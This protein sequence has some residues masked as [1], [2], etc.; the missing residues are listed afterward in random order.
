MNDYPFLTQNANLCN[1]KFNIDI[2]FA[3]NFVNN[4][5]L[6]SLNNFAELSNSFLSNINNIIFN[7][8]HIGSFK[9]IVLMVE[10]RETMKHLGLEMFI[11]NLEGRSE[12]K[13]ETSL[14]DVKL[15]YPEP[16]VA[17]PSFNHEEI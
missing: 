10:R 8:K 13:W 14:P 1:F 12:P 11:D 16:F 4:F 6:F 15:Y 2:N 9:E 3:L 5:R 7:Y 17:S